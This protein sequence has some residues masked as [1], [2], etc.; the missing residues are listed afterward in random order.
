[1][2]WQDQLLTGLDYITLGRSS[3]DIY[4]LTEHLISSYG[5]PLKHPAL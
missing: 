1:M 5:A 3:R 2:K 4:I